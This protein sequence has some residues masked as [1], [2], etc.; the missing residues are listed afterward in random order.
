M[1]KSVTVKC[2]ATVANLVCGFDVLGM[3]L[4]APYDL[5]TITLTNEPKVVL[6][7]LDDFG[8]PVAPERNVAGVVLLAVMEKIQHKY[9]FLVSMDKRIKPGSGLGSSAASAAGA[10][11]AANLLLDNIF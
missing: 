4:E 3:A 5:M 9:G 1:Q 10:A 8:L 6:N 7:N 11:V 2:P